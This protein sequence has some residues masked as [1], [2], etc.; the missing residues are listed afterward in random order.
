MDYAALAKQF[1]GSVLEQPQ[2]AAAPAWTA[3]LSPKD[4]GE[5]QMKM[6]AEGRKRLAELQAQIA[7]AGAVVADLNEFGRLNRESS[8][9]SWWQQLTPDKQMFR[10]PE[11]MQM[12]AITARLAPNMRPTGSGSTSDKDLALYLKALPST[13]N[14][15]EVN[16]GIRED[17]QRKYD[18][19]L[20]KAAA[21]QAH[22]DKFGNLTDFDSQWAARKQKAAQPQSASSPWSIQR[23]K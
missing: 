15:G 16:K 18:A 14:Y 7:D 13:E 8:T 9:G 5:I 3:N 17:F 22:L 4:Q 12:A 11:S 6:Y 1:G 19:A 20:E 23:V 10:S 2:Q 21:M